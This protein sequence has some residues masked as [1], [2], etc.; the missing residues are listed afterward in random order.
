MPVWDLWIRLFHWSLAALIGFQLF[1]GKTGYRFFDWHRL[2]GE[3][4]L[5]LVLFRIIWGVVGSSN[6]RLYSLLAHPARVFSHLKLLIQRKPDSVRGHNAAGG[7]AVLV[8]L[9]MVGVQAVTGSLIAD[10]DELVEGAWYGALSSSTTDLLYEIH[11]TN[12]HLLLYVVGFHVL[13]IFVYL[14]VGRQNLIGPMISGKMRRQQES[15]NQQ[16]LE[17]AEKNLLDATTS[18]S[19]SVKFASWWLGLV[20]ALIAFAVVGWS[21]GW[22]V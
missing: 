17:Q 22:S 20:S 19:T 6:A 16:H 5:A 1:S 11:H 18:D 12:A 7:C 10:E 8:M 15:E 9:L 21:T 2:A 4:I 13:M 3:I 14:I